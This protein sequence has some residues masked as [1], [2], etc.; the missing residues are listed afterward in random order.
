MQIDDDDDD[1]TLKHI[2]AF[3]QNDERKF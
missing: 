1:V 3:V 2:E